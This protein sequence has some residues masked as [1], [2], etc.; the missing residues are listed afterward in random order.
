M[1]NANL[2]KFAGVL[3]AA[4]SVIE[5]MNDTGKAIKSIT[6]DVENSNLFKGE[7]TGMV[8]YKNR[9]RRPVSVTVI[10]DKATVKF[11]GKE[12]TI[13]PLAKAA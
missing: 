2:Q 6:I 4:Y 10:G 12:E 8:N 7:L 1:L 9:S 3:F 13:Y 5:G 11:S